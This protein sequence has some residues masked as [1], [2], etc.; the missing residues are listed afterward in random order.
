MSDNIDTRVSSA[1]HPGGFDAIEGLDEQTAP[2]IAD[3]VSA[4]RDAYVTIGKIWNATEAGKSNAAWTD[5]NR[6]L[7]VGKEAAKQQDR[8]LRRMDVASSTLAKSIAS[9]EGELTR[10]LRERAG[11]GSINH[12]IRQHA[13]GLKPGERAKLLHE[14]FEADDLATVEAIIGAQPFLSGM[15]REEQA[16]YAQRYNA[17][18]SPHLVARLAVMRAAATKMDRDATKVMTE[19]QKAVG[20]PHARVKAIDAANERAVAALR[21]EPTA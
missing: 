19:M 17:R 7:I 18:Q 14:A 2:F 20:A 15:S 3:A 8:L 12:E 5:E 4:F 16:V 10:L 21:I 6:V 1:L 11:L 9:V 13:K